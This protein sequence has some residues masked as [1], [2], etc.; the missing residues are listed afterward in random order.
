MQISQAALEEAILCLLCYNDEKC[1]ELAVRIKPS[2]FTNRVNQTIAEAA[3]DYLSKYENAPKNQL[4]YILEGE[5]RR[6]EYGKLLGK[7]LD[8]IKAQ[9]SQVDVKFVMEQLDRYIEVQ[10]L[11]KSLEE[12]TEALENGELEKAQQLIYQQGAETKVEKDGIWL[13]DPA[14][15][16][17]E[18]DK[19]DDEFFSSGVDVLDDLGIRPSRK[20]MT[21]LMG[22]S[23]KGKSWWLAEVAKRGIQHHHNVLVLTLE[24][25]Q[26]KYALRIL[27]SIFSLT[28]RESL[29][30]PTTYFTQGEDGTIKF[31][32]GAITRPS[33]K[34][35]RKEISSRLAEVKSWGKLHI[36][37]FPMST[38]TFEHLSMYLDMLER[39]EHF[40]PDILCLDYPDLMYLDT[41]SLRLD[42]GT[43]YRRLRGLAQSRNLA[44][45]AVTQS[46]READDAKVVGRKAVSEDWSKIPTTDNLITYSQTKQEYL[47]NLARI[48]V[49]KA[50]D[51]EHDQVMVLI[52]Q[53][54]TVGQFCLSSCFMT[55]EVIEQS[56]KFT[57]EE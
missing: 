56:K 35:K 53:S 4:E 6:G 34:D 52:S 46:N 37:E 38:L 43:L 11:S 13:S 20:T 32:F 2:L 24:L 25:S 29:E 45:C 36:K 17:S 21:L 41:A 27:Q 54:Y 10:R 48:Y 28:Q 12:A 23:G 49:A 1:K 51:S 8:I 5:I 44:L 15:M 22:S 30:I 18:T 14:S 3:I 57:G 7:T 9:S 16:L 26:E 42:T 47:R 31:K 50:R 39:K 40:K 19:E 33:L 55:R